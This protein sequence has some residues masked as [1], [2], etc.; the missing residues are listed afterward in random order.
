[1][2]KRLAFILRTATFILA[3]LSS[4]VVPTD[5]MLKAAGR[6]LANED[7]QC[8]CSAVMSF[9]HSSCWAIAGCSSKLLR[10]EVCVVRGCVSWRLLGIDLDS[11]G[12]CMLQKF[13]AAEQL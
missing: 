4:I 3:P 11:C 12:T 2:A 13:S 5:G 1:M 10:D 6:P 9:Y 8:F 7:Q